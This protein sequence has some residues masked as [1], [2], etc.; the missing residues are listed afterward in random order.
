[1]PSNPF[2]YRLFSESSDP[3]SGDPRAILE[4]EK[5]L[6][7]QATKEYFITIA[8]PSGPQEIAILQA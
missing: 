7:Q 5:V 8:C 1:M 2:P 3:V 6:N 4:V